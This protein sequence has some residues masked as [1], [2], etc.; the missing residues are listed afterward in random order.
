M[1]RTELKRNK[2]IKKVSEKQKE[3]NAHWNKVTDQRCRELEFT[4]QW[5][6]MCGSRIMS[7]WYFLEGH[8]IVRRSRGRIDTAENC[9]PCHGRCHSFITDNNVDINVYRNKKEWE[10]R[11]ERTNRSTG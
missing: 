6:G 8:H 2:P 3:K 4:C 7:G 1:K 11:D 10:A 9:Y 5:C